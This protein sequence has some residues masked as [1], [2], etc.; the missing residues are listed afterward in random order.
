VE[1]SSPAPTPPAPA[2]PDD[3]R[4]AQPGQLTP[5][6]RA[7][8]ALTWALVFV[9]F[10][11]VWKVSRELGL[12]TWWLGPIGRPRPVPVSLIPF[13]APSLMLVAVIQNIRWLPWAGLAASGAAAA[14]AVGD[15]GRVTRLGLVELAIAMAGAAV[16]VASFGG[17]YRRAV[18]T[19]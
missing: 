1:T 8:T 5:A 17:R 2:P 10:T 11:G 12:A 18:A 7:V 19:Q 3:R 14:I 4:A 15:L 9:A 13:I 6:W 16:S